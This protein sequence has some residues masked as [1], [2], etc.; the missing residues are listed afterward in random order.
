LYELQPRLFGKKLI[1]NPG[2]LLG[3]KERVNLKV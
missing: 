1:L 3:I 2:A